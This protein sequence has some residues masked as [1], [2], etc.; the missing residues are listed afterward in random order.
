[1]CY[2][3]RARQRNVSPTLPSY[4]VLRSLVLGPPPL[5]R[6]TYLHTISAE[7]PSNFEEHV[8]FL[9]YQEITFFV[10][11]FQGSKRLTS[12]MF[13]ASRLHIVVSA[14]MTLPL[15]LKPTLDFTFE[16]FI[17]S[18]VSKASQMSSQFKILRP[19]S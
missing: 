1:M 16:I 3:R 19:F 13:L 10:R 5:L 6:S 9:Q 2:F 11:S 18:N 7:A 4:S 8:S 12:L 15:E 17:F 14:M